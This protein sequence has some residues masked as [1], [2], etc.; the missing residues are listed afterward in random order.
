[1]DILFATHATEALD[2]A[3]R[4]QPDL[5]LLDVMMPGMDGYTTCAVL[6][7]AVET[8]DIPVIFVTALAGEEDEARGLEAGA[9]DYITKPVSPPIVRARVR[10]HLELKRY[11][12]V[13]S[14]L[15]AMDGLTGI[16][17]SYNFV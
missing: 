4:E 6:K 3:K 12:D 5:I 13:L 16:A 8:R 7:S 11:R 17:N 15:S 9:I 10:N 1:M 2:V 14:R